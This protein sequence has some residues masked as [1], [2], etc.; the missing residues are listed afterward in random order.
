M[1]DH[2]AR[3]ERMERFAREVVVP[4]LH[5]SYWGITYRWPE[6]MTDKATCLASMPYHEAT[7]SYNLNK[8]PPSEDLETVTHEH[9]HC[10]GRTAA[11]AADFKPKHDKQADKRLTDAEEED[12]SSLTAI[13]HPIFLER[14]LALEAASDT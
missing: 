3:R 8:L 10:H 5:L 7:I 1:S 13:L 9:L 2:A 12:T 14:F 4:G 11:V 6:R